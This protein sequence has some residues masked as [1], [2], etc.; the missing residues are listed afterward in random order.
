[1]PSL[2]EQVE[3]FNSAAAAA[4][5]WANSPLIFGNLLEALECGAHRRRACSTPSTS[6]GRDRVPAG[7]GRH[8]LSCAS[9]G[10]G[11]PNHAM[12]FPE[13]HVDYPRHFLL[14]LRPSE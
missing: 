8:E 4:R 9:V 7:G 6:V 1:M 11:P 2:S 13:F 12:P 10:R 14:F 3:A 5:N